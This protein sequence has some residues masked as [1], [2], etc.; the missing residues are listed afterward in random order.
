MKQQNIKLISLSEIIHLVIGLEHG[1]LHMISQEQTGL[2]I[3]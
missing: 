1:I 2:T 3:I